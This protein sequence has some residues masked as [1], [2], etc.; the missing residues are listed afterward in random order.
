MS[1][2]ESPLRREV[3]GEPKDDSRAE[4]NT[5]GFGNRERKSTIE[6]KVAHTLRGRAGEP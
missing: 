6:T 4:D 1:G 5:K 3:G 2:G